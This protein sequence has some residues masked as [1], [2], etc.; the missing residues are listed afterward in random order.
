MAL[1]TWSGTRFFLTSSIGYPSL[2]ANVPT[3]RASGNTWPEAITPVFF[4]PV[5]PVTLLATISDVPYLSTPAILSTSL[6]LS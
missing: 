6:S 3:D 1:T 5:I 4:L 2:D